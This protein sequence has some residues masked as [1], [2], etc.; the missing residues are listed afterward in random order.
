MIAPFMSAHAFA[1]VTLATAVLAAMSIAGCSTQPRE[2]R[3]ETTA[4]TGSP[5]TPSSKSVNRQLAIPVSSGTY[6][7]DENVRVDITP[8][9]R[10][11]TRIDVGWQGQRYSL[12]RHN[13]YSGLPR[14]EDSV[15]QLVWV[16]L[17]WKGL[18]LDGRSGQP[19]ANECKPG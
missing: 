12:T 11:A 18:L 2:P 7:C 6:H 5:R 19:L 9:T 16:V 4:R 10:D 13:S 14:Y 17:P 8:D 3:V 15:S 1:R